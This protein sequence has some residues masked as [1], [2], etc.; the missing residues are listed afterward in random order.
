MVPIWVSMPV[1]VTTAR[2]VPWVTAVP[3]NTMSSRS[4]SAAGLSEGA[5]VLQD[6]FALAGERGLVDA[7][8]D[9]R[10]EPR[11]GADGV[12]LAEHEQVAA[13]PAR[14]LGTRHLD[15]VAHHCRRPWRSCRCSAATACS[16]LAS[17]T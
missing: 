8:R 15:A 10:D 3:L 12:A 11:V 7:Q 5:G 9:G 13:A 16:A 17:C 14:A 1:A 2:P 6:G 4:P